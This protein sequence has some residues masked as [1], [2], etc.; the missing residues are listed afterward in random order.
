MS[1]MMAQYFYRQ[2]LTQENKIR[3][4]QCHNEDNCI[5]KMNNGNIK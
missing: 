3:V 2:Q 5:G 4:M 1:Y